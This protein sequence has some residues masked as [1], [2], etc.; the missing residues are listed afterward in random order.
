MAILRNAGLVAGAS[1]RV[2]EQGERFDSNTLAGYYAV[3][4]LAVVS[5]VLEARV[6][7][8][9]PEPL[10]RELMDVWRPLVDVDGVCV[11]RVL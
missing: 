10:G 1:F 7:A 8:A 4:R 5:A 2:T 3:M 6:T 9:A 11:T